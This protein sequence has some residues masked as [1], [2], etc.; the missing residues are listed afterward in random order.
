MSTQNRLAS[1]LG[2]GARVLQARD[3][4]PLDLGL[5]EARIPSLFADRPHSSR[6]ARYTQIPTSKVVEGLAAHGFRPF[7]AA[8]ATPRP[9]KA[10]LVGGVPDPSWVA[11]ESKLKFTK[12]VL[13]F[14][15][16]SAFQDKEGANELVLLNSH[17][18][19][20]GGQLWGGFLRH[21]CL[22][23]MIAGDRIAEIRVRHSGNIVE[24]FLEGAFHIVEQFPLIDE[25]RQLM[26]GTRVSN[27]D[28]LAFA[29]A[30]LELRWPPPP[31]PE[32]PSV[33]LPSPAPVYPSQVIQARDASKDQAPDTVWGVL[34]NVQ[35]ALLQ[36]GLQGATRHD[37]AKPGSRDRRVTTRPVGAIQE[38]IRL[39]RALWVLAEALQ[40]AQ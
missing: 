17:G 25:S 10:P 40:A 37:P 26:Q 11:P 24:D 5:L 18:G 8:Q 35:R 21:L 1:S 15:H 33:L 22:N 7:F 2:L 38:D 31:D 6:S 3:N 23:R 36:G 28:A 12:H 39:N 9:P 4:R 16:E 32:D 14:R 19:E 27:H 29:K 30:A 34:G 13:R 20:S